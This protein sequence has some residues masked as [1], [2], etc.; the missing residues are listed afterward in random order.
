[1]GATVA[2]DPSRNRG[3]RRNSRVADDFWAV[4]EQMLILRRR[5]LLN[6]GVFAVRRLGGAN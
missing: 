5:T 2:H 3:V 6:S 4:R 1:M